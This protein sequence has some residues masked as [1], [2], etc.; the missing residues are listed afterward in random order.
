MGKFQ[1]NEMRGKQP[2]Y[3]SDRMQVVYI[4]MRATRKWQAD[5]S[6][7]HVTQEMLERKLN[8]P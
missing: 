6:Y 3:V 1:S 7:Q 4:R 8:I 2:I 5:L